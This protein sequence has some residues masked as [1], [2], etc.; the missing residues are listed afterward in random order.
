MRPLAVSE[1]L[2]FL[3]LAGEGLDACRAEKKG[4]KYKSEGGK[5]GRLKADLVLVGLRFS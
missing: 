2:L 1:A 5:R 4:K 3:F